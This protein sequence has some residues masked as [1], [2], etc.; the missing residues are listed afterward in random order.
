MSVAHIPDFVLPTISPEI[1]PPYWTRFEFLSFLVRKL[2]WKAG[3]E[4]GV[5][6]GLTISYL[7]ARN[8][9]LHMIGVDARRGFPDHAGP[10]DFM[11]WPHD[12]LARLAVSKLE[13][14]HER[15]LLL[16]GLSVEAADVVPDG[17]LDFVF[18]DADHSE[19]GCRADILAWL[20]KL[21][22]EGWI[23]GHDISWPGVKRAVSDTIP[24]YQI[25]PDVV[26]FRPVHPWANWKRWLHHG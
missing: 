2:D 15:C 20:P 12:D 3:A 26:W 1:V 5:S 11:D 25:G 14:Y 17:S 24:G 21:R 23:T 10:D 19:A 18:I 9:A 6:D 22:A 7:L 4:I 13:P 8:P 16:T